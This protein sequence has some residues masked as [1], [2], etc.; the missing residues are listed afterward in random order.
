MNVLPGV[1]QIFSAPRQLSLDAPDLLPRE[2]VILAELDLRCRMAQLEYRFAAFSNHMDMRG[3]VV[4]RIDDHAQS[5]KCGLSAQNDFI[6]Y[7]K[8]LG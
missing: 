2:A 8:R 3:T 7:P 1:A 4:V 5:L 6:T